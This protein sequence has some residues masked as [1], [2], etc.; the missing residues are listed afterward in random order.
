M[1]SGGQ[2]ARGLHLWRSVGRSKVIGHVV[3]PYVFVIFALVFLICSDPFLNDQ[4]IIVIILALVNNKFG[5]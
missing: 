3:I 1:V 4:A 5:G 2:N